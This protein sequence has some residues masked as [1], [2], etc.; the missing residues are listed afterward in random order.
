MKYLTPMLWDEIIVRERYFFLK[1]RYLLV[2]NLELIILTCYTSSV[3]PII[4][5]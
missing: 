1:T 3:Q 4:L 5:Y 2:T